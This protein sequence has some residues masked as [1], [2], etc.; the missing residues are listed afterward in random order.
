MKTTYTYVHRS[1]E[2]NW[3][4]CNNL[5]IESKFLIW[6]PSRLGEKNTAVL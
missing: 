6:L 5:L 2:Q 4:I 3:N 1:I